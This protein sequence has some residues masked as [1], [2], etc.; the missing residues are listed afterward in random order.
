MCPHQYPDVYA[1]AH[2]K[3]QS[4]TGSSASAR[5]SGRTPRE[6]E[7]GAT[8]RVDAPALPSSLEDEMEFENEGLFTHWVCPDCGHNDFTE[9]D[10][11]GE[12]LECSV[13]SFE[14]KV[15]SP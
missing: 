11:R 9:G 15:A 13:C 3:A 12:L 7:G 10:I 1:C 2:M 8:G 6:R 5:E 14:G 4:S